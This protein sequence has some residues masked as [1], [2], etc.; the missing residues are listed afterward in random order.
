MGSST[1]LQSRRESV[2]KQHTGWDTVWILTPGKHSESKVPASMR[3]AF[4]LLSNPVGDSLAHE[5]G[6][7]PLGGDQ[8]SPGS[9]AVG[10]RGQKNGR[11]YHNLRLKQMGAHLLWGVGRN[12]AGVGCAAGQQDVHADAGIGQ[13]L[14][15]DSRFGLKSSFGGAIGRK[16]TTSHGLIVHTDINDAARSPL[17]HMRHHGSRHVTWP[18]DSGLNYHAPV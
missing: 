9:R 12:H 1:T 18:I 10:I 7:T 2:S 5:S 4:S 17:Q 8:A 6:G 14:C 3:G 15:P 13:V 16:A 11:R